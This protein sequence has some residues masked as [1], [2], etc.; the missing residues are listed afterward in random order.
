MVKK[1]PWK[2]GVIALA[3]L[4]AKA[5]TI[6]TQ[7]SRSWNGSVVQIQGGVLELR[8]YF[9]SGSATVLRFGANY[10]RAIEFNATTHNPTAVPNLPL[11]AASGGK[12]S[13]TVYTQRKEAY[14]CADIGLTGEQFTCV[15]KPMDEDKPKD[16]GKDKVKPL[17]RKDVMRILIGQ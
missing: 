14:K 5:D 6:T 7:D 13:G 9:A 1:K 2:F 4:T 8:A 15:G 10:I 17:E 11:P 12:L 16:K 3:A